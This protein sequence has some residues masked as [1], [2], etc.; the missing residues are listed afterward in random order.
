V[1]PE[2]PPYFLALRAAADACRRRDYAARVPESF[3]RT[4]GPAAEPQFP[5]FP[6][7]CVN[8]GDI[9]GIAITAEVSRRHASVDVRVHCGSCHHEWLVEMPPAK[10]S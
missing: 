3:G 6:M 9:A 10:R 2:A 7:L 5:T 8:C 4:S 1:R